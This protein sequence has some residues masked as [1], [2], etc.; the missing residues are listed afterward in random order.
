MDKEG[1]GCLRMAL[2][3]QSSWFLWVPVATWAMDAITDCSCSST[4]DPDMALSSRLSPDITM[5]SVAAPTT[6]KYLTP[7]V[8][9]PQHDLKWLFRRWASIQSLLAI[10][11]GMIMSKIYQHFCDLT[12]ILCFFICN[13]FFNRKTYDSQ[14]L[15]GKW[16]SSLVDNVYAHTVCDYVIGEEKLWLCY[17]GELQYNHLGNCTW[18][19]AHGATWRRV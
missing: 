17:V 11:A 15:N 16:H 6:Q 1:W 12:S 2:S 19:F 8:A 7:S 18:P 10:G 5:A 14:I 13:W 3:F 4:M 9:K